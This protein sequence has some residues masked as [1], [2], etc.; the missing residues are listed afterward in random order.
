L[1]EEERGTG[2]AS[3]TSKRLTS[4]V[5]RLVTPTTLE[6]KRTTEDVT[7]TCNKDLE[8]QKS[9]ATASDATSSSPSGFTSSTGY[10]RAGRGGAGNFYDPKDTAEARRQEREDSQRTSAAA[11]ALATGGAKPRTGLSGRGG[12]GNWSDPSATAQAERREEEERKRREDLEA[13]ILQHV[14]A[15]LAPPPA[16]YH[17]QGRELEER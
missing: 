8:A 10:S 9:A 3:R 12:V 7:L 4:S 5:Q 2:T 16:A 1:G 13:Q 14:D 11:A 15:G 6:G 17:H